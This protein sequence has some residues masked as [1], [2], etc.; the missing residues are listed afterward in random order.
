MLS[1]TRALYDLCI[2]SENIEKLRVEA[3]QALESTGGKWTMDT[4]NVLRHMDS[5]IKESMRVKPP[6]HRK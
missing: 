1:I 2:R 6:S 4:V 5:F 3:Q